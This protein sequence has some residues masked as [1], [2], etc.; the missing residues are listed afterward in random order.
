MS[1]KGMGNFWM[2]TV[3]SPLFIS[4]QSPQKENRWGSFI[5]SYIVQATAV[6][7][8]M[9]YTVAAPRFMPTQTTHVELTAPE[10]ASVSKIKPVKAKMRAPRITPAEIAMVRPQPKIEA[11]V[12]QVHQPQ[13]VHRVTEVPEVAQ[14]QL[15]VAA[16]RLDSKI[17]TAL[18]KSAPRIVATNTFGSSA[19]PTLQQAAPSKV[20]TG[21]FGDPNGV[22]ASARGSNRSNIAAAGS[23][24][25]PS[26]AGYGNGSGGASGARGTIASTG[27]GNGVAVQG[28]NQSKGNIQ[29]TNFTTAMAAPAASPRAVSHQPAS[30]P[31]SIQSKPTPVYTPEARQLK[32]EGEVLLNVVFTAE[33]QIRVLNVVRGLGHGLDEAARRAA[34]GVR[35]SP[36]TRD[37]HPVDSNATLHIIFQL[38]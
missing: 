38:S 36:A 12:L 4:V 26:G 23:F 18:P 25:L 32:V 20:Q 13:R 1:A 2:S 24:D 6:T 27:F 3:C 5:A 30:A 15:A 9:F 33:G 21:G 7:A 28:G 14:P 29:S 8:L 37:G 17:L 31:V 34:Q 19:A 16:P 22:P 35:F 10:R 11:P